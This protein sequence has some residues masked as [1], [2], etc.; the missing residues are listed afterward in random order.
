M[1]HANGIH[2][3]TAVAGDP[4]VNYK[5]YSQVLGLRL[6][7]K[8]VNFDDPSVY[9]LYYG[10]ESGKPGTILT[11]FPWQ[12][13][14]QGK[15]DRGQVVAIGFSVPT[16]S[17]EFW[18]NHLEEQNIDFE[19]PFTR[20][21]KEIIGIQ[22]PHGLHLELVMDPTADNAE[23]WEEGPL[24]KT[25]TIRGLHGAT[26]AE[27][28]YEGTGRLLEE[29]LGFELTG[30]QDDRFLYE[31]DSDFGSVIEIIDQ[32]G[33][34]GN[35]GKGTVHHI[36]FRA[37]DEKHQQLLSKKLH[38]KGYYLTEVKDRQYF[39]SVYFHEPGGILF[40]IATDPPGF[41]RDEEPDQLG[42]E[43]KLPPWLEKHR[44]NIEREL[45]DLT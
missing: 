26:L 14:Q 20:F 33:P 21:G 6:V 39:K 15:P 34:D 4:K 45:P 43:L 35:P 30:Q 10:N 31:T 3:I 29:N 19:A 40:E 11:F 22:D 25:H 37:E 42:Q 38:N 2:H 28:D 18:V 7:K 32:F 17:K 1:T 13:L 8:T 24:P 16:S 27:K 44:L 5:F 36:A 12:H 23:G 41:S 9:H